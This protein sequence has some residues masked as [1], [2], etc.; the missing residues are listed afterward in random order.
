[1]C[2]I[3][4]NIF[5]FSIVLELDSLRFVNRK[6]YGQSCKYTSVSLLLWDLFGLAELVHNL[7][8]LARNLSI[9]K[10]IQKS[11]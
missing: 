6:V 11:F 1:M 3:A 8:D 10:Y 4:I 9:F 7:I 5:I 2:A